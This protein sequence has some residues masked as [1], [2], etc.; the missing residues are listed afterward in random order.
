M[1]TIPH[2]QT[3]EAPCSP[4][5]RYKQL[6]WFVRTNLNVLGLLGTLILMLMLFSVLSPYFL[7]F[8]NFMNI[9]RA[10][11]VRGIVAI[12]LTMVMISGGLD[13]SI[14][15]VMAA[16]GMLTATLLQ[17]GL[18]EWSASL[19]AI[20]SG[21]L[22]GAIN[23]VFVTKVRINPIIATLGS[24]S[25]MRGAGYLYSGGIALSIGAAQFK[26]LGRGHML[27]IPVPV[28]IWALIGALAFLALRYTRL[29][30]YAFAIGGNPI[31][32]RVTGINVDL[33]RMVL[34][35]TCGTLSGLAGVVLTSLSGTA[36]PTAAL[37]AE[38]DIVAAVVLGGISLSGGKGSIL[39]T[40]LGMLVLGTMAN[41]MTLTNVSPYWQV[42]LRGVVLMAAVSLD[43][44]R[45][46]PTR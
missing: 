45:T 19:V 10:V 6:Q 23:G 40:V 4:S 36:T 17:A 44:L 46:N 8:D 26:Y 28:V 22:M 41:G 34:Y 20:A 42:L 3:L 39:G 43:S 32:C 27:G 13:L 30:Q 18:S 14:A 31:A 24:M 1:R 37:G 29:G 7:S 16:A 35:I 9:A 21:A 38:L 2:V 11:A 12:G 33:W 15:S 25:I 5:P